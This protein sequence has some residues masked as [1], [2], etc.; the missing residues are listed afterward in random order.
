[1]VS[2][3]SPQAFKDE[4]K[5]TT[6]AWLVTLKELAW[7]EALCECKSLFDMALCVLGSRIND[8][9]QRALPDYPKA[10]LDRRRHQACLHLPNGFSAQ[11]AS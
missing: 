10:V 6:H 11:A 1:M 8:Q 7:V 9:R 3:S 2:Q 4:A 5:K